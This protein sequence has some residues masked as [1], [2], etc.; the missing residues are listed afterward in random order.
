MTFSISNFWQ[1]SSFL[2][3]SD[4]VCPAKGRSAFIC[5]ASVLFIWA[6]VSGQAAEPYK[7][8]GSASVL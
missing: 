7:S 1:V 4:S 6:D 8:V 3:W 2:M 5:A